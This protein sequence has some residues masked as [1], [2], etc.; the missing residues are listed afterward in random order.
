MTDVN[1]IRSLVLALFAASSFSITSYAQN[2]VT[3]MTLEQALIQAKNTGFENQISQREVEV[4]KA[5][6]TQ[7][8]ATFMPQIFFEETVVSTND[9]IGVFGI[10]LRQG[11]ISNADF[12]PNL[13]NNPD[14][15]SNFTT[16]FQLNQPVFNPDAFMQRSAVKYMLA[17]A[18]D[19]QKV[20]Q[21]FTELKVKESYFQLVVIDEQINVVQKYLETV[22]AIRDQAEDYF[23]QGIINRA[24]YLN[25]E[26]QVLNTEK[27]FLEVL[28]YRETTNDQLLFL[29]GISEKQTIQPIDQIEVSST[30]NYSG[31]MFTEGNSTLSAI[32]N[33]VLASEAML[34]S[35]RYRFLPKLNVFGSYEFNDSGLFGT[36]ADSYMLGA[37]LRWD[38][39]H[40]M[41]NIGEIAQNRAE[42]KKAQIMYDQKLVQMQTETERIKRSITEAIKSLELSELVVEQ[43]SEDARIRN[44]R[45][46]Q[47]LEK[48]TDLLQ[49]ESQLLNNK[50]EQLQ[51]QFNYLMAVSN[52]EF[53]LE[54]DL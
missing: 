5:Q 3:P 51:V 12:N 33:Q 34:K 47:G 53:I 25:A 10:K 14:A 6:L 2:V 11:I 27:D 38:L 23:D 17:S 4:A 20:T 42:N 18:Q 31:L 15:E 21:E 7:S 24:E 29:L 46:Q 9:P 35:A 48:T 8:N 45:Y 36:D 32:Q 40:G 13:L 28:N 43:S 41:K 26:V 39:F 54:T 49:S 1:I 16:K 22:K 30:E 19:Q 52:L 50:L 44:D 37:S